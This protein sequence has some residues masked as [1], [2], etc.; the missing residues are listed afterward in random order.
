MPHTRDRGFPGNRHGRDSVAIAPQNPST[1]QDARSRVLEKNAGL[2]RRN[3]FLGHQDLNLS[4]RF[5]SR[6]N[7]SFL[8]W[9]GRSD[10]DRKIPFGLIVKSAVAEPIDLA[11]SEFLCPE[12][13]PWTD[14]NRAT[15]RVELDDIKW[16]AATN[17]E[18]A[19]LTYR[20][21]NDS[22]VGSEF[23][24]VQVNNVA[25]LGRRRP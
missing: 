6:S 16:L 12:G 10:A 24:P 25:C 8:G 2:A 21:V 20:V 4:R 22:P 3:G 23:T 1:A 14:D 19:P 11:D 17:S 18:S 5:G 9:A 15:F 7:D 13:F